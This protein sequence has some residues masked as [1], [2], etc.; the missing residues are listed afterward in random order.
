MNSL[1]HGKR[2]AAPEILVHLFSVLTV[3]ISLPAWSNARGVSGGSLETAPS[4]LTGVGAFTEVGNTG[5][6]NHQ[7]GT[8]EKLDTARI[9]SRGS[10]P[11][12]C[13]FLNTTNRCCPQR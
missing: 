12:N 3:L 7:V 13:K 8:G 5:I 10:A 1:R 2:M 4:N 11:L 6:L 9:G